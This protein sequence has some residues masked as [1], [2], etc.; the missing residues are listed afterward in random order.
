VVGN[1]F[2]FVRFDG[3]LFSRLQRLLKAHHKN[4]MTKAIPDESTRANALLYNWLIFRRCS[5]H[6]VQNGFTWGWCR[7]GSLEGCA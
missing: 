3:L 5:N 7:L 2:L 4:E 6:D 1:C